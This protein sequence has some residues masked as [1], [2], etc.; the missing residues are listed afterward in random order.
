LKFKISARADR[1]IRKAADWWTKNRPYAPAMFAEDLESAFDLIEQF[2]FAGE[3]MDH[4]S[5]HGLRRV[6]LSHAQYHLYYTVTIDADVIEVLALWH[7]SRRT[8]ANL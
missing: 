8:K 5:I 7:T 4:R 1:E 2:P 3:A 6:L